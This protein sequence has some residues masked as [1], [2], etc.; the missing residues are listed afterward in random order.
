[1]PKDK[2][3]QI[4]YDVTKDK[5]QDISH[6]LLVGGSVGAALS[7]FVISVLGALNG[8][9]MNDWVFY[10]I[11]SAIIGFLLGAVATLVFVRFFIKVVSS[12]MATEPAAPTASAPI[13]TSTEGPNPVVPTEEDKGQSVDFVFPELT[14]DK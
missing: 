4:Y 6:L 1:M 14:P 2:K 12:S 11:L 7:F 3:G 8:M 5:G 10:F 13:A 9:E